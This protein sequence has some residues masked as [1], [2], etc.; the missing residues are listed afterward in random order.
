M[1][2]KTKLTQSWKQTKPETEITYILG[3][4]LILKYKKGWYSC[5]IANIDTNISKL[6]TQLTKKL[7]SL[8]H[9]LKILTDI[10]TNI[11]EFKEN[12]VKILKLTS[13]CIITK[14]KRKLN[15]LKRNVK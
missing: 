10:D 1:S 13:K 9:F 12:Q 15:K 11:K 2:D 8:L 6:A 14:E 4:F 7:K 3:T 5:S